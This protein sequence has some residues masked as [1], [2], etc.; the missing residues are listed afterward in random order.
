LPR[1]PEILFALSDFNAKL[2]V[3]V[4]EA[5]DSILAEVPLLPSEARVKESMA[6]ITLPDS[7]KTSQFGQ[8]EHETNSVF[9]CV[10][11]RHEAA[12]LERRST[13]PAN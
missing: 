4:N 10:G 12:D 6:I 1:L 9:L 11:E 8:F 2:I 3:N 7:V 13:S 5:L